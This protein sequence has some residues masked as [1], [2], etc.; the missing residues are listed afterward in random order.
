M[1]LVGLFGYFFTKKERKNGDNRQNFI[2][3]Q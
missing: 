1:D 3:V 2:G